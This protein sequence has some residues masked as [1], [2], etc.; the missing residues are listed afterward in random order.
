MRKSKKIIL[1]VTLVTAVGA[2]IFIVPKA[3]SFGYTTTR[4]T[5]RLA[6]PMIF[7]QG[8]D[9]EFALNYTNDLEYLPFDPRGK[10]NIE[11]ND[12]ERSTRITLY[13]MFE[14]HSIY[15]PGEGCVLQ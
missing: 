11:Q 15:Y 3:I 6:C 7:L 9:K 8:R 4:L 13:G 1:G 5:A 2:L 12:A 10:I 14:A